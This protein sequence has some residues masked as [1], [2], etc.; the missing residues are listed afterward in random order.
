MI[1]VLRRM[2]IALGSL[3]AAVLCVGLVGTV[4]MGLGGMAPSALTWVIA[5]VA[6]LVLGWLIY[7]DILRRDA[8]A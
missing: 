6:S 1:E 3:V 7:R 2:G 5:T 8:H 4:I